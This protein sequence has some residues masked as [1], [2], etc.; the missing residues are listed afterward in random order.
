MRRFAE[1]LGTDF[2]GRPNSDVEQVVHEG[3]DEP[4]HRDRVPGLVALLH[5]AS[6]PEWERLAA[7]LALTTWAEHAGFDA[8]LAAAA[9]PKRAPWYDC[10]VDRRFSVDNTFAQLARAVFDADVL[11]GEKGTSQRRVEAF[12]ALVGVADSEFFDDQL[13][14][15][16][17]RMTVRAVLPE[18][19]DT[20][21]RGLAAIP[22]ARFDLATQLVDLAAAVAQVD[23]A[24]AVR[25]ARDVLATGS[26]PRALFHA[27]AIVH[28]SGGPEVRAFAA[29]LTAVGDDRVRKELGAG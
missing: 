22:G 20:V 3:L 15:S 24:H 25:L 26:S 17:D 1:L 11:A 7:C 18:I 29:H 13:A 4:R 5:D 19:E 9:D 2:A 16:L 23:G 14:D 6:A 28:R 8:V 10:L 21:T 27:T 12:R